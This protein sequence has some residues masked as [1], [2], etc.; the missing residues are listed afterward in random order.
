MVNENKGLVCLRILIISSERVAN[1]QRQLTS[2]LYLKAIVFHNDT[3]YDYSL[4]TGQARQFCLQ[5]QLTASLAV[6][7]QRQLAF[8]TQDAP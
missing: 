3:H 4:R 2:H 5:G 1:T 7:F 6:C 8:P